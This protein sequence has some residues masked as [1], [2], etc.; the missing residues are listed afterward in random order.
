MGGID[1]D[2]LCRSSVGEITR[3]CVKMLE[4]SGENGGYALGSG[5]SIPDYVPEE[6]Y[7]AMINS[8]NCF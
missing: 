7:M 3:R 6:A 8:V 1:I 4:L 2:F 5:N